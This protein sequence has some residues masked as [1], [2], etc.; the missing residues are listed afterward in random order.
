[1]QLEAL[2]IPDVKILAPR[3]FGDDR[4]FFSETYNKAAFLAAAATRASRAAEEAKAAD[5]EAEEKGK[6]MAKTGPKASPC[7][8]RPFD[9]EAA[10]ASR[11]SNEASAT[12]PS[13]EAESVK[14]ARRCSN[15]RL[16]MIT[17]PH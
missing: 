8:H 17:N 1:M 3:K 2:E 12:E 10:S 13:P 4:G 9:L 6:P 11:A 7:P 5:D 14:K 15:V 16:F